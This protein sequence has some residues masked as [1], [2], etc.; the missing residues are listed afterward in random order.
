MQQATVDGREKKDESRPFHRPLDPETDI[1][2]CRE[3]SVEER[4]TARLLLIDPARRILL[5]RIALEQAAE[6]GE[7]G[8]DNELWVTLGGRIEPGETVLSAAGR[9]LREETGIANADVGPVVWYGEQTLYVEG[10]SRLLKENFVLARCSSTALTDT[11]WT[12]GE[13]KAIA[14]MRWWSLDELSTTTKNIKPPK[15]ATLLRELLDSID[16]GNE[17][18]T[19]RT[20]DLQ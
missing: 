2:N 8:T 18:A 1:G 9:E 10:A 13:R 5:M 19:I 20:I 17:G 16:S 6:A 3:N 14:E 7:S 15:L 4:R 11:G 12:E